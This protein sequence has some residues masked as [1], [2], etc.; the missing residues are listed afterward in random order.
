[1]RADYFHDPVEAHAR[2]LEDVALE[3]HHRE[4]D[5][6]YEAM[7]EPD[8]TDYNPDDRP[9]VDARVFPSAGTDE[10]DAWRTPDVEIPWNLG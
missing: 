1:M 2:Y 3:A 4:Q 9:F 6:R 7:G 5:A 10:V 8:P